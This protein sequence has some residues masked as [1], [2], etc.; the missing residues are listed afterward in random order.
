[1]CIQRVIVT[2][3]TCNYTEFHNKLKASVPKIKY[4]LL[5]PLPSL[6]PYYIQHKLHWLLIQNLL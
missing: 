4:S 2:S 3:Q 1:M 5:L 6:C